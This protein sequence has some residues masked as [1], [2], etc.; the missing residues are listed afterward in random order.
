MAPSKNKK[1]RNNQKCSTIDSLSSVPE[2]EEEEIMATS[3]IFSLVGLVIA[4]ILGLTLNKNYTNDDSM[5]TMSHNYN[6]EAYFGS[7]WNAACV[8]GNSSP[9]RI[10]FDDGK[11]EPK[12]RTIL[13]TNSSKTQ[14][15]IRRG[16]RLVE[17]PRRLQIWEIDAIRSNIVRTER[18]LTARH[19]LTENPLAGGAILAA[20]L[21]LEQNRLTTSSNIDNDNDNNNDDQASKVLHNSIMTDSSNFGNEEEDRL[22]LLYLRSLP[23]WEELNGYHPILTS[24]SDLKKMLGH[25]SWNFAVLVMYQE[26][27]ASEYNALRTVSPKTFGQEVSIKEYQAAR[28]HVLSR[29][30]NPGSVACLAEVGKYLSK[31]EVEHL[32]SEW[33]FLQSPT[34]NPDDDNTVD[35][36]GKTD[37]NSLF[38]RGCHA[39]VPILDMLNSHPNPNV[40]YRYQ[41]EKQAFTINAK[42]DLHQQFELINSYGKYSDAHLYAKFG[43]VNG[44]GSGYT[45]ASIA[46]FHRPLDVQMSHEFTMIPNKI[47]IIGNN[48]DENNSHLEKI[49]GFQQQDLK[50]YLI[51]DDGYES[52]VQKD[53][54][55][56]AFRLKHL[57]WVHL[58]NIANN[59]KSWVVTLQ[60][61]E[62]KSKPKESTAMLITESPPK[63]DP[64]KLRMDLTRLV[65]TCRLAA[66]TIDDYDGNAIQV[67]EENLGNNTFVVTKGNDALEYRSLMFLARLAGT[68][69]L[70]SHP[71]TPEKEYQN[72]LQLN[73]KHLFNNKDWIAA[74]LRLGEMQ[75]RR[76]LVFHFMSIL[77]IG[78]VTSFCLKNLITIYSRSWKEFHVSYCILFLP[79]FLCSVSACHL[80]NC[81]CLCKDTRRE[82]RGNN[83]I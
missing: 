14:N 28:I 63:I 34:Q 23:T 26:M 42:T 75:V 4:I 51:F 72:I 74:Q 79:I 68:T 64:R 52:C 27:V 39:M 6:I 10:W 76:K 3:S 12:N 82:R 59:P 67:L 19:N 37:D 56:S 20:Y 38:N 70:Q 32:Q 44:D 78:G 62:P 65:E 43:F 61:R 13:S 47:S 17:I 33:G 9:I 80:G 81:P 25:H 49:P 54:H 15:S 57:K 18:L 40:V 1:G 11:I 69:L 35:S 29:S 21:A 83:T 50:R 8:D 24:K 53:L 5:T 60:P 48:N 7:Y 16:D 55:P 2:K 22:R 58:A 45:Q 66:L 77:I 31:S 46:L 71:N 30:F 41:T 36:N 73:K